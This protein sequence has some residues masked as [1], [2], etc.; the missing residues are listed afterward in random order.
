MYSVEYIDGLFWIVNDGEVLE[1]IGGF[2][3]PV[4]PEII[5]EEILNGEETEYDLS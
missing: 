1:D 2:I 4:T 3:D 5:I